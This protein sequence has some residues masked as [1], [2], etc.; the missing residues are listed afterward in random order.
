MLW[1]HLN[2]VQKFSILSFVSISLVALIMGSVL[3]R[4][5]TRNV[6]D[7]EAV[8]TAQ[9]IRAQVKEHDLYHLFTHS[10]IRED[11]QGVQELIAPFKSVPD[12]VQI[13]LWDR[14]ATVLWA[15]EQKLIGR[16]SPSDKE[17]QAALQGRVVAEL[18]HTRKPEHVYERDD[19]PR[20]IEVYI[21][22]VAEETQGVIGVV[23]VYKDPAPL[24][25]GIREGKLLIWTVALLGGLVLYLSLFGIV[26][27]SYRTQIRLEQTLKEHADQLEARVAERTRELEASRTAA[28]GMMK[29]A[30]EARRRAEQAEE[31]LKEANEE[32]RE[33]RQYLTR[34][35]ESATDAI[36]STDKEGNVILFNKGAEALLGYQREEVVGQHVT[37]VY[38]SDDRAKEV[39]RQMR[40][41]GDTVA[42]FETILRAKDGN[43]IPVL[44]SASSLFD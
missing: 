31:T 30:E 28:L 16:Q 39:M 15:N 32:V 9:V 1:K 44:I 23:E 7:R 8:T 29:E 6:L 14:E 21:P 26:R 41:H 17:V 38:E 35:I 19:H 13:K 12:L 37:V 2:L 24:F 22:V 40:Q 42:G 34:L 25:K 5:L 4:Y 36:I 11:P 43:R 18:S 20:V 10:G 33:A 27:A 3:S